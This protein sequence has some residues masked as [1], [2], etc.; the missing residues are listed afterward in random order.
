MRVHLWSSL[1]IQG[2]PLECLCPS[3]TGPGDNR[4]PWTMR[5]HPCSSQSESWLVNERLKLEESPISPLRMSPCYIFFLLIFVS[6]LPGNHQAFDSYMCTIQV[7]SA[8]TKTGFPYLLSLCRH[9]CLVMHHSHTTYSVCFN[10]DLYI[11]FNLIY[12]P[13]EQ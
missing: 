12:H 9:H 10:D 8:I 1:I 6:S 13:Q 5:H 7:G 11:F 2:H 4:R 3:T